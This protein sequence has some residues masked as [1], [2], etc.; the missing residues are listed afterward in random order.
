MTPSPADPGDA[1]GTGGAAAAI[2]RAGRSLADA[3]RLMV[4]V[5][6]YG[7]YLRHMAATHPGAPV[8][9]YEAFFRNRQQAR[10]GGGK[11]GCC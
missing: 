3:L 9:D 4:G 5:P 10:Y 11:T 8:M 7:A 6:N 2:G 1:A